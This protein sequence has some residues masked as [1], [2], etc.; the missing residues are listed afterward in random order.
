MW[1]RPA[2]QLLGCGAFFLALLTGW[3]ALAGHDIATLRPMGET[4][5]EHF[6]LMPAADR[7]QAFSRD[8]R[9]YL[10]VIG[11]RRHHLT[12][13]SGYAVY[14]FDDAGTL[15]GWTPDEGDDNG[16]NTRWPGYYGGRRLDRDEAARWPQVR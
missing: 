9:M 5:G 7:F 12:F 4:L 10:A 2:Y 15:V 1:V 8:G 6:R 16:F 14:V 11:P 13:P 3:V